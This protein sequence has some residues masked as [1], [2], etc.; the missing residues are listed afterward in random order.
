MIKK[1]II[2][3]HILLWYFLTKKIFFCLTRFFSSGYIT[4][5]N[6]IANNV[7]KPLH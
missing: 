7:E 4:H 3:Y 6:L 5:S 1:G 2:I